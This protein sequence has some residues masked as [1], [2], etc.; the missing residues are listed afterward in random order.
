MTF[1]SSTRCIYVRQIRMAIGLQGSPPP[2]PFVQRLV[3]SSCSSGQGFAYSF[4]PTNAS[5]RR[6][7]CSA[8]DSRPS[9][10][11]EDLH[12][13]VNFRFA[14]AYRLL[15]IAPALTRSTIPRLLVSA[16]LRLLS[17]H[18]RTDLLLTCHA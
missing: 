11:P 14:F 5:R 17:Q 12:L 16:R 7:C 2:Y 9:G 10:L 1:A 4:L 6:S 8:R 3:C 13:L 15:N 18:W